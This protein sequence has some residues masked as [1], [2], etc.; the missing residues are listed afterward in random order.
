MR[1]FKNMRNPVLPSDVHIPDGEARVM[2]DGKLYMGVVI[3]E[4]MYSA[5]RVTTSS[6]LRIWN[7]GQS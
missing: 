6:Q 5:V 2:T 4:K 3:R 1:K 7:I